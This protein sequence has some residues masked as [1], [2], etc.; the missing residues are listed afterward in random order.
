MDFLKKGVRELKSFLKR[1]FLILVAIILMPYMA[2]AVRLKDIVDVE[3]VRG[4]YLI[5][6]G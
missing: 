1:Y 2:W 4:N 3:G 5:G 6:Y